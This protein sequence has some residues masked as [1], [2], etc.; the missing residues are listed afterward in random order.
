VSLKVTV[1]VRT[2]AGPTRQ[3]PEVTNQVDRQEAGLFAELPQDSV[4]RLFIRLQ[5]SLGKLRPGQ[6]MVEQKELRPL[7]APPGHTGTNLPHDLHQSV[8]SGSR[9][10]IP[11]REGVSLAVSKADA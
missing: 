7:G 10:G 1:L 9:Q 2:G 3:L 5:G 11:S 8:V 4:E 6:R